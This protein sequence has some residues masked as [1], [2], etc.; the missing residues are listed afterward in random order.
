MIGDKG[1]LLKSNWKV[2]QILL[3]VIMVALISFIV[4]EGVK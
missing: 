1:E 2:W 3:F 4:L